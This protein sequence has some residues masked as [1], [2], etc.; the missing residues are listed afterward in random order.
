[1]DR[2]YN[3]LGKNRELSKDNFRKALAE[4]LHNGKKGKNEWPFI[5]VISYQ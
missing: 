3:K 1:M 5:E 2:F 4:K